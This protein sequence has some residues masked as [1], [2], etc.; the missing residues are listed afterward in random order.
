MSFNPS[1]LVAQPEKE[2]RWKGKI[3]INGLFDGEHY[4]LM[5]PTESGTR[6]SQ[7]EKFSGILV[8]LFSSTFSATEQGFRRMNEQLKERAEA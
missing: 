1:V 4:F 2:F 3:L 6:F 5:K 8:P 7:G